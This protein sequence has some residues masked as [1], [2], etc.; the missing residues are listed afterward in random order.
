MVFGHAPVILP[1]ILRVAIPYSAA[2]YVPLVL[3]HGSLVLRTAGDLVGDATL[4]A[5]GASGNALAIAV[6]IITAATLALRGTP[7]KRQ[8]MGSDPGRP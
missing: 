3:L 1:A 6:F 8:K 2:L 5:V 7:D 4:R